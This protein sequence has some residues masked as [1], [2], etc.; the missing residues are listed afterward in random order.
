MQ[1]QSVPFAQYGQPS[2]PQLTNTISNPLLQQQLMNP[3]QSQMINPLQ[4]HAYSRQISYL[5]RAME[6]ESKLSFYV[7]V[8][9]DLFPGTSISPLQEASSLCSSRYNR[10]RE[11]LAKMFGVSYM[12][13]PLE[14][15]YAYQTQKESKEP[16][17]NKES[18]E[19]KEKI[20]LS[21]LNKEKRGGSQKNLKLKRNNSI[22]NKTSVK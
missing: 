17:E 13:A 19:S 15:S 5:N 10:I 12:A 22:K 14:E 3:Y 20:N 6:L 18:K 11:S 16:K 8:E 7:N 1:Q 4:Q 2:Y 21:E 9:V